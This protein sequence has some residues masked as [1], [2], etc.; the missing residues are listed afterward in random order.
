[1]E[2]DANYPDISIFNPEQKIIAKSGF[3]AG[4]DV[5]FQSVARAKEYRTIQPHEDVLNEAFLQLKDS[6]NP[7]LAQDET[8]VKKLALEILRD[9]N[10][11]EIIN[12]KTKE[13]LEKTD[14]GDLPPSIKQHF[15]ENTDAESL[16]ARLTV[17][18]Q[19]YLKDYAL[20][21]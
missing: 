2:I 8:A 4:M 6:D 15:D 14:V 5:K 20:I 9:R 16:K 7:D 3:A 1:M 10:K 19:E 18:S 17:G 13:L 21:S 11:N 12:S